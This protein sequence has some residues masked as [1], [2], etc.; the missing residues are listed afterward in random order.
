MQKPTF[1][2]YVTIV[3]LTAFLGNPFKDRNIPNTDEFKTIFVGRLNYTTTEERLRKEFELFGSVDT[4]RLV[5]DLKG[6][7]RGYAFVT[8]MRERDADYAIHKA[9]D[10]RIDNRRILVDRELGRTKRSWFP[11]R[12]GGGK[13][14]EKRRS[15]SDKIVEEVQSELRK[16]RR[17]Q[18]EKLSETRREASVPLKSEQITTTNA[19]ANA[20]EPNEEREPGEV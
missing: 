13:G 11:R 10:R 5:R 7:S 12:L 18:E 15:D 6:K 20:G 1:L 4:V 9:Q 19:N 16:E 14:G 2:L 17:E 3:M 8:F